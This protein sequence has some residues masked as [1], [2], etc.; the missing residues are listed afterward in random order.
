MLLGRHNTNGAVVGIGFVYDDSCNHVD[1]L[2][3]TGN[4]CTSGTFGCTPPPITFNS[5]KNTFSGLVYA[6]RPDPNSGK[7]GD[8]VISVCVCLQ[9]FGLR[10]NQ[11]S[12]NVS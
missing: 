12:D 10:V 3:T 1:S 4:P 8:D 9:K 2:T 5:Y 6:C 11:I 7:C